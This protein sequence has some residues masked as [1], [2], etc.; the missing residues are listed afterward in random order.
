[1]YEILLT[2]LSSDKQ[3]FLHLFAARPVSQQQQRQQQYKHND[4]R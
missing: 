1:M 4:E 2:A 3:M